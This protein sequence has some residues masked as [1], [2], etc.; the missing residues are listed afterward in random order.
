MKVQLTKGPRT[1]TSGGK[2]NH[3]LVAV[4]IATEFTMPNSAGAGGDRWSLVC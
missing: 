2:T 3:A 4:T 1:E